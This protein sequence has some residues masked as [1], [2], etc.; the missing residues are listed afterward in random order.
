MDPIDETTRGT[1]QWVEVGTTTGE[2]EEDGPM[3]GTEVRPDTM[4]AAAE[5]GTMTGTMTG[6][7]AVSAAVVVA[8]VA[9]E[10]QVDRWVEDRCP[11]L[12]QAVT[13]R[14]PITG[15]T[16]HREEDRRVAAAATIGTAL[17]LTIVVDRPAAWAGTGDRHKTLAVATRADSVAHRRPRRHLAA[18]IM[19]GW[20]RVGT[21]LTVDLHQLQCR[22]RPGRRCRSGRRR[23]VA[24][25]VR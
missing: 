20:V 24:A 22:R 15:T 2:E 6:A 23:A 5:A 12:G 4:T 25:A 1:D 10:D 13:T 17:G 18:V 3:T 19:A 14:D 16:A 7:V 11:R 8:V 9:V 21:D